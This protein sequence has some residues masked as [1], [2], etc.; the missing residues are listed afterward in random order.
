VRHH[1][2]RLLPRTAFVL[3][4]INRDSDTS[5]QPECS[6]ARA[7]EVVC[8]LQS[9]VAQQVPLPK[10]QYA[11]HKNS[12]TEYFATLATRSSQFCL[13]YAVPTTTR[14]QL[15]QDKRFN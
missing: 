5:A 10:A 11:N 3:I 4:L 2:M 14:S 6:V 8:C 1:F 9:R 13:I 12:F 7:V 15:Q